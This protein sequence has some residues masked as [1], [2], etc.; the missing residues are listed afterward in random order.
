MDKSRGNWILATFIAFL[1]IFLILLSTNSE[2][3]ELERG[4]NKFSSAGLTGGKAQFQA[5]VGAEIYPMDGRRPF[6]GTVLIRGDRI[7]A[8]APKLELPS[9]TR[10]FSGYGRVV[11]PG[12]AVASSKLGMME[13]AM[14]RSTR[15]DLWPGKD[16]IR[17]AFRIFEGFDP[18]STAI[19]VNRIE[20]VTSAVIRPTGGI[21][22]GVGFLADLWG[23]SPDEMAAKN[24]LAL[25]GA[26]PG[27]RPAYGWHLLRLAFSE[28]RLFKS[29][30]TLYLRRKL[31]K[32]ELSKS[33][34]E[35]LVSVLEG[36]LPLVLGVHRA[37][38]IVR[39]VQFARREK[40]R[41]IIAG[42]TEAWKVADLL[43]KSGTPVILSPP[44][45][46][47]YTFARR[48]A[49]YDNAAILHKY[50]VLF[51]FG[52]GGDAFN[53]RVI[54]Q[55]AGVAA[56]YGLPKMAALSAITTNLYRIFH[57]ERDYGT[58]APGKIANLVLWSG[59]T[60]DP[61]EL[62]SLAQQV[63]IRGK[64]IYMVSR[65]TLLFQRYRNLANF[66]AWPPSR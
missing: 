23:S 15:T 62:S 34:L 65:Q 49:R 25:F 28:A 36:K 66:K 6:R 47:P 59:E 63:W 26:I 56:S 8:V 18:E 32:L 57:L 2:S 39:A 43:A 29:Y 52:M 12:I 11:T 48:G 35:V 64:A 45:N 9:G 27:N 14:E 42:A 21:I 20:G 7:V 41:L 3:Q 22:S 38:D 5:I 44:D 10:V 1:G 33:S 30:P 61:L 24:P 53:V 58:I 13:V 46:L 4:S 37:A 60:S 50:G 40:I 19:P 54:R 51:A 31:R 55:M 16:P 17:A